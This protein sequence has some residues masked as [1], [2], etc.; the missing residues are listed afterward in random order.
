MDMRRQAN[1]PHYISFNAVVR[2]HGLSGEVQYL[3]RNLRLNDNTGHNA[4]DRE[5]SEFNRRRHEKGYPDLSHGLRLMNDRGGDM[6]DWY[7]HE[8]DVEEIMSRFKALEA[9]F[10]TG[11][12]MR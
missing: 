8:D 3:S 5:A 2:K 4:V 6:H 1:N 12:P 9:N 11:Q 10:G 7:V